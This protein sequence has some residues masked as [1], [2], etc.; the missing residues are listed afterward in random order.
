MSGV[1]SLSFRNVFGLNNTI[2]PNVI[3]ASSETLIYAAGNTI[4]SHNI[5]NGTQKIYTP[6]D[7][8]SSGVSAIAFVD[9]KRN[10]AF[11][12]N[13]DEPQVCIFEMNSLHFLNLLRLGE[14][15]GSKGFISLSFSEDGRYLLGHGGHPGWSLV[16]WSPENE[17][18]IASVRT[19]DSDTPVT[20]CTFSPGKN[21]QI[22]VTGNNIL[23][24]YKMEQGK[25]IDVVFPNPRI[26]NI[27]CHLWLNE[28]VLLCANSSGDIISV[29]TD[30]QQSV[31]ESCDH[32][33][34]PFVAMARLKRGFLAASEG[35]YLTI[36][37]VSINPG[38]FVQSKQVKLFGEE[39]PIPVHALSVDSSGE[40]AV[41]TLVNNR[42]LTISLS[43]GDFITNG[44]E[45]PQIMPFHRGPI[46]SCSTCCRK[47]LVA[48]CGEDKTVRVWNYL[49]NS[50]EIVKEFQ[51]SVY[52]VSFNP[53]GLSMLIGFGDKLRLCG[54]FY[55]DIR[56]IREF[57]IRGCRCAKFSNGGHLFAAVNGS[58]IQIYSALTFQLMN[59][60]HRHS[61]SVHSLIWGESDTV[62]ASVGND[63]AMYIHRQDS[64]NRDENCTTA[65]VQ[66]YSIT[67][68]PDFSSIFICGSDNKV[69][70]I[71]NG[72]IIR[73]DPFQARYNQ[74]I[75]S[76]NGQMLFAGTKDGKVYSFSL[77]IGGEKIQMNCH[78]AP[79]TSMAISFDDS[80]LFTVGEDGVLC[81][82][83]I[84]DKD[85]RIHSLE[86]SFFSEEVM[87][88]RA[89]IEE[90]AGQLRTLKAEKDDLEVSFKM[91]KDMNESNFKTREERKREKAKKRKDGWQIKHANLKKQKDETE[92]NIKSETAKIT[93][94]WTE[95]LAKLDEEYTHKVVE[96]HRACES[97][98]KEKKHF[99]E[100][101]VYKLKSEEAN[102]RQI[103]DSIQTEHRQLLEDA[104][105]SLS[106]AIK[107]KEDEIKC[108]EEM[109][110]EVVSENEKTIKDTAN[111]LKKKLDENE[112]KRIEYQDDLQAKMKKK[113]S[114]EKQIEQ[115][116]QEIKTLTEEVKEKNDQK[117]KLEKE[118]AQLESQIT[119]KTATNTEKDNK[120]AAVKK[121]NHELNKHQ[122][123]LNSQEERLR[124]QFAPIQKELSEIE[125]SKNLMD[126]KLE[127]A[128]KQTQEQN[129]QIA[130]MQQRLKRVIESERQMTKRL[131]SS[132]SYF[133]QAK[134]DLHDVVQK[135]HSK[136]I[137]KTEFL[138]FYSK[139]V[140]KEK[141]E[142]IQLDECVEE[143]HKRQKTTLQKQLKELRKQHSRDVQFQTKEQTKLLEQNA[144]LIEELQRL[145]VE[146]RT[147]NSKIAFTNKS[148]SVLPATEAQ[149]LIEANKKT[150]AQLESQ[151]SSYNDPRPTSK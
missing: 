21:P 129:E 134:H 65:Q 86:R 139:Y 60:L 131:M 80:L 148:P 17:Q 114:I 43:N 53:D 150:I 79:I 85:N 146:N 26:G 10:V 32:R 5:N 87:T 118:L 90:K 116:N 100:D 48:T 2:K 149:R 97:L 13:S 59:T 8:C 91:K 69:K 127:M 70:E 23:K 84:R 52:C 119:Q 123:V 1:S 45:K 133:E 121:E 147:L 113:T 39:A 101:G 55:D 29:T 88:T 57:P 94:E 25:L 103:L 122:Q 35:G 51:E 138:Q 54:V 3:L 75:M 46:L 34:S 67:S 19:A 41:V 28:T 92:M 132:R 38:K 144:A 102:H 96:E 141:I 98:L 140:E 68:M 151:L 27:I 81:V 42:I 99:E 9:G 73:E 126:G 82:F 135:F 120:L 36:F 15:F 142:D 49:D 18:K 111:E 110:Q 117:D 95:R 31:I 108:I 11:G 44:E 74:V 16:I 137:L 40:V 125:K 107:K 50:L 14:D 128:H 93:R 78:T 47:P 136:D 112:K 72:T 12:D 76:N 62:I 124:L 64:G 30:P 71:Q 6:P 115:N 61:A 105:E 145:R 22:A 66:Y 83:S 77:P 56:F 143:E 109:K 20:Q 58:K 104:N 37:D 4:V 33:D 89:E 24:I 63:G 106:I 7:D 130:E